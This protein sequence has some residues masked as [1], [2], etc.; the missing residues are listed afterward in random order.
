MRI[1]YLAHRIPYPPT[2]GE[3]IRSFHQLRHL[4]KN[5]TVHLACLVDDPEDWQYRE[6]L[7]QYCASV[8]AVYRSKHAAKLL[9]AQAL[10]SSHSFS[11]ASFFSPVLQQAITQLVQKE[12]IDC[13]FVSTIPMAE[14]V[15]HLDGL[16]KV[17]DY[18]DVDSEKWRQY[19]TYHS[20]PFSWVYRR[21]A[22]RLAR[23]EEEAT[24]WF[25]H[26]LIISAAEA[27]LLRQRVRNR[28]ISVVSNGVDLEYFTPCAQTLAES[29]RPIIVFTGVMDYFPNIDAVSY[30]CDTLLP[31]VHQELPSAEFLIVGRNPVGRVLQLGTRPG[32]T[33]TGSVPDVRP[34]LT[35]AAVVVA[36]F[37]L[38]RGVQ[39]KVLEAMA[40]GV[41]VVG[42]LSATQGI[43]VTE[44]DGVVVTDDP[45]TFAQAVLRFLRG[46]ESARRQWARQTRQY[47]ERHHQWDHMGIALEN[48]LRSVGDPA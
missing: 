27:E 18:I 12:Q 15:K 17:I 14:Y 5:H 25:N 42:T 44:S 4:A 41:P 47:V 19:A 45:A 29:K 21:E 3:K 32:V 9:A 33:V 40:M 30:F 20:F 43:A 26:V 7:Q 39:N 46:D 28:P 2:K 35:Q 36:P 23:Y 1:L 6:Q 24:T 8:D 16:G 22:E 38:A 34:Y 48:I 13:V 37:R 31:L 11:V 10:L